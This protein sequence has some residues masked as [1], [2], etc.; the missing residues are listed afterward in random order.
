MCEV[1]VQLV[2]SL[3]FFLVCEEIKEIGVIN[4]IQTLPICSNKDIFITCSESNRGYYYVLCAI[5]T[6]G[7]SCN[8]GIDEKDMA[9]GTPIKQVTMTTAEM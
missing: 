8:E 4:R 5:V 1:L 2:L 3:H 6:L 9:L 7:A